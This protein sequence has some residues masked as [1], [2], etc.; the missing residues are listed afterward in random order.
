M[1]RAIAWLVAIAGVAAGACADGKTPPVVSGP[2]VA[3][4]ADQVL[5]GVR[6]LLTT[7]GVQRGELTADTAYVLDDQTRFDL[8]NAHAKFTTETGLPQGTM[9]G[10]RAVYSQRTQILEGWGNVIVKLVDGRTLK[11]PHV[12]YNQ[13]THMITS[14]TSYT[15]TGSKGT[16]Y[17]IGLTSDQAFKQF[18]CLR[19]CG[20]NFS[21][22]IPDK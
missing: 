22:L 1:R 6:T 15:I 21:A 18:K 10:N 12:T 16:Q 4:S 14:D 11:S 20:G 9:E 2:S 5:F 7:R 8:R 17:G 13:V 19:S 3:D